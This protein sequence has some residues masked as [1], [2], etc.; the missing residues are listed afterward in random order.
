MKGLVWFRQDLRIHDNPALFAALSHCDEVVAIY[1]ITPKTWAS[2]DHAPIKLKFWHDNLYHLQQAL[3]NHGIRLSIVKTDYFSE[4][5]DKFAAMCQ[6]EKID[7]LYFNE[8][9]E[10]E[11]QRRDKDVS[12]KL[13]EMQIQ[14][15]TFHD[16]VIIPPGQILNSQGEPFKVFTAFKRQ[17][18]KQICAQQDWQLKSINQF[19]KRA[20]TPDNMPA[21]FGQTLPTASNLFPPGEAAALSKLHQFC[22]QAIFVYHQQ[23]DFPA[24][25]GTSMLS[26]YL[27]AGV[28]SVKN[29]IVEIL[30]VLNSHNLADIYAH[31]GPFTW[32]NELIWREFYKHI[33]YLYPQVCRHRPFL[34]KTKNIAWENQPTWLNSWK[35]GK[36]GFPIVDAA[37]RQLNET[38]WMHNRLRM[39][40]AMFLSKILLIDWRLGEKYFSEKL[41][42][43]DLAA[44]NG[45]WQWC[46]STGTD[47]VPYFRIFNPITQSERFDPDGNFIRQ[48]CPELSHLDNKI[49]HDPH[50]RQAKIIE[51][52]Y[53]KPIVDY[54]IRRTIALSV[55]KNLR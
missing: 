32:L 34:E 42:D 36:T 10:Y 44:N 3:A 16:Q 7:A 39:I 41:I 1:A 52:V 51:A 18:L 11:E 37:M 4:L 9:Y 26:P 27:A 23:R 40:S 38:G 8:Q 50:G 13:K 12:A 19:T 55:F 6:S 49:I 30:K 45:G 25:F 31:E 54:K 48:Y 47:A 17:W 2:H 43:G 5:A 35:A 21:D 53:P 22:K 15:H 20:I 46:A 24:S 33:V 29:C 28:L 14:I